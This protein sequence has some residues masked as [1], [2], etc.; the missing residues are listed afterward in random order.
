MGESTNLLWYLTSQ[1]I[2][3]FFS[4]SDSLTEI[5]KKEKNIENITDIIS[6]QRVTAIGVVLAQRD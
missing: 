1:S 2:F 5:F 6:L 3:S 4:P